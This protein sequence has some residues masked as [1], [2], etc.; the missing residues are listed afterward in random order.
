[1]QCQQGQSHVYGPKIDLNESMTHGKW[2]R[3]ASGVHWKHHLSFDQTKYLGPHPS[4][5]S[6][7]HMNTC[8]GTGE[9]SSE[10]GDVGQGL[11][12][13]ISHNAGSW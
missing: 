5:D 4:P 10:G 2:E 3:I 1:M 6:E 8:V 9:G 7:Y 11:V 12:T 13:S